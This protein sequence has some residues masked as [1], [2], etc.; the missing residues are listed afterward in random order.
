M[1]KNTTIR[2]ATGMMAACLLCGN[3]YALDAV[4]QQN[5]TEI[6]A[7]AQQ[8]QTV[9]ASKTGYV[10]NKYISTTKPTEDPKP[11]TTQ[12]VY[13]TADLNVRAQP[14]T[15]ATVLGTL[16]KGTEV[17]TTTLK[18]GWYTI[19]FAGKTGYISA[20]YTTTTKPGQTTTTG[21]TMFQRLHGI[22]MRSIGQ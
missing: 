22:M 4:T 9:A 1:K 14:N 8:E 10:Y 12:T 3:A 18:D 21:F 6:V 13:T 5:S 11:S 2:I 20:S 15:K 17:Q 7:A 19:S 16:K